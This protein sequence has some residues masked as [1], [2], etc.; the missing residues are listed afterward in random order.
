MVAAVW[1]VAT[2][3]VRR[4]NRLLKVRNSSS[5]HVQRGGAQD[6]AIAGSTAAT[7]HLGRHPG[8]LANLLGDVDKVEI[9][10]DDAPVRHCHRI[11]IEVIGA[12]AV[13]DGARMLDFGGKPLRREW[14]EGMSEHTG[15]AS[16]GCTY[17]VGRGAP[18]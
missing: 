14:R 17:G 5:D 3:N 8:P 6:W 13:G 15:R 12:V 4:R 18:P 11:Q 16:N 7:A 1:L 9:L 10:H 2:I